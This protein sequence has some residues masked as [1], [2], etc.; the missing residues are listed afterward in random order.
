MSFGK[1]KSIFGQ[2]HLFVGAF[3]D[4]T[5]LRMFIIVSDVYML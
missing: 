1:N 5:T 4:Y 2:D 3:H